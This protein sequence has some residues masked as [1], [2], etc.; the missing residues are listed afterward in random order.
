MYVF[1]VPSNFQFSLYDLDISRFGT[2][3]ENAKE[4]TPVI[5]TTGIKSN[6]CGPESFTP[7]RKP[8][9]GEDPRLMGE[10]DMYTK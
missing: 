10:S 5:A 9:L 7:D 6:I 3:L 4:L 8:I 1:Q 2:L